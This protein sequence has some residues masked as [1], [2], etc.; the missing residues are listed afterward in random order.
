MTVTVT[1]LPDGLAYD[2]KTGAITGTT[3][4]AG[5]YDVVIVATNG[6]EPNAV[7]DLKL[8]VSVGTVSVYRVYNP[9]TSEHV[10]TEDSAEKDALVALGWADEGAVWNADTYSATA[11]YRVYNPNTGEHVFTADGNEKDYLVAL[12]WNDEGIAFYGVD[13]TK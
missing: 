13:T 12:G 2:A 8:T 4:A 1:G 3:V 9:N 11:V 6:V 10:Y 7:R 5:T